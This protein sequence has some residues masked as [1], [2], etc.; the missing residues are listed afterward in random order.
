MNINIE[1]LVIQLSTNYT[2]IISR[3]TLKEYKKLDWGNNGIGD[4]WANKKFNYTVI[5]NTKIKKYSEND[6]EIYNYD[7]INQFKII[8]KKTK[9]IIGILVHSK[10][11]NII[12]R[13][14][15]KEI[16][17]SIKKNSCI[18]C[19]DIVCDHKNDLYN[20]ISVLN[21]QTQQINDF[22]PLCNH[23]NLQKRQI[24]KDEIKNNKIY[25]AKNLQQYKAYKFE[26]P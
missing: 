3:D 24:L 26:F 14:I 17:K 1:D 13:P 15:K 23:C 4:R 7:I 9:G 10:R 21:I 25:S 8:N 20:D 5:Y 2:K 11:L 18:S 22:Q 19:S 12:K 6:E 16:E